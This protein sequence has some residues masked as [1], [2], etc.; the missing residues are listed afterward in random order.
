MTSQELATI[1][2]GILANESAYQRAL[3]RARKESVS[4]L[5]A[6]A[7]E[8]ADLAALLDAKADE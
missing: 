1:A 8:S 6:I 7:N 2:S 5:Q 3:E 4:V